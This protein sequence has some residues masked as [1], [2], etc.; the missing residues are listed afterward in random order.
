MDQPIHP[1]VLP[2]NTWNQLV[3]NAKLALLN[4]V[5]KYPMAANPFRLPMRSLY[6]PAKI[7]KMVDTPSA[8]PSMTPKAKAGAPNMEDKNIGNIA[9]AISW[10]QS[11]KK[12][13]KLMPKMFL[14][15]HPFFCF[16]GW[17]LLWLGG[18]NT[19]FCGRD[20]Y[21]ARWHLIVINWFCSS[22]PSW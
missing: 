22:F 6:Q 18:T 9:E 13:A 4:A 3:A 2:I 10:F 16:W 11:L 20:C 17:T 12:L 8:T 15:S 1:A 7:S 19:A 21:L 14:L 5:I